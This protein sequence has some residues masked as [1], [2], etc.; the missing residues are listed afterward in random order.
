[1]QKI[2]KPLLAVKTK[3][4]YS[5][6]T[7]IVVTLFSTWVIF[8]ATKAEVV[9]AADG[10][11]QVVKTHT[12]TVGELL[13]EVGIQV[14]EYDELSHAENAEVF[15]GMKIDFDTAKEVQLTVDGETDVHNTTAE[16]VGE[17]LQDTDLNI[18]EHD[19]LSPSNLTVIKDGLEIKVDKAFEVLVNDGGKEKKYWTTGGTVEE[20]L[21][22]NDVSYE[23]EYKI[24]PDLDEKVTKDTEISIIH[25]EK[26]PLEIEESIP[27]DTEEKEDASLEKGKTK[28]ISEGTEGKVLKIYEITKE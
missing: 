6:F 15:D 7:A 4:G 19:E 2:L 14:G 8:D 5:V 3:S 23:E 16:T 11:V 27:F 22:E 13:E 17:F 18:S 12:T 25:V 24:K 26:E 9:I 28:T 20:L 10:D 1:M 21:E